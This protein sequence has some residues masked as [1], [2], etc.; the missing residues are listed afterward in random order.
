M[1]PRPGQ[2]RRRLGAFLMTAVYQADV[3][4]CA[5][6][7][8]GQASNV[9]IA[10][11]ALVPAA[12][13]ELRQVVHR[14]RRSRHRV[15][16]ARG[17]PDLPDLS[18]RSHTHTA[19]RA[20]RARHSDANGPHVPRRTHH[21]GGLRAHCRAVDDDRVAPFPLHRGG[22]VR[23]ERSAAHECTCLGGRLGDR[24]A[25]DTFIWYGGLIN[26]AEALGDTGV[27]RQFAGWRPGS[28]LVGAGASHSSF[29][30]SSISTLTTAS[31]ASPRTSRRCSFHSWS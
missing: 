9:I 22:P 16:V 27:T 19:C 29:F 30:C 23:R 6:F 17:V 1:I 4:T 20:V 14:R 3:V 18:A 10:K 2:T 28:P 13:T 12:F 31:R 8:T 25:W 5:M 24:A 11:F 26:M 21:A 7:L 15:L